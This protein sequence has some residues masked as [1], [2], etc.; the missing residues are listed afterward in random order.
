MRRRD[1]GVNSK[2]DAHAMTIAGRVSAL[3]ITYNQRAFIRATIASVVAQTYEDVEIVV[4]DDGSTDGTQ[5]I[6]RELAARH[7]NVVPVLAPENRGIAANLNAGWKRCSGEFIAYLGGDDLMLPEK[8]ARQVSYMRAHPECAMCYHDVEVFDSA[9]DRRQYFMSERFP[10]RCGGVE[11]ELF[12]SWFFTPIPKTVPSSHMVRASAMPAHGFDTRLKYDNDWLHGVEVLLHG[13]RGY[14]PDVLA[15]YR[16]HSA[17]VSQDSVPDT[18]ALAEWMM[19]HAIL[20]AR[21]PAITRQ[22]K[23]SRNWRLFR[24]CVFEWDP[25]ELRAGRDA[26]FRIEAGLPRW[27]YMRACRAILRRRSL[28]KLTRSA[29]SLLKFAIGADRSAPGRGLRDR[30]SRTAREDDTRR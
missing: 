4:A 21:Y 14:L 18:S 9:T 1:T 17:Q 3:I 23:N 28:F 24:H 10:G 13:R 19:A 5:D 2:N 8:L 26:Q 16:R 7:A 12:S 22:V 29:R 20:A 30:L 6:I 27:L 25:P 11:L 15:R